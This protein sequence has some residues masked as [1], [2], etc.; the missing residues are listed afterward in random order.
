MT[1]LLIIGAIALAVFWIWLM[2]G[3]ENDPYE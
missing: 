3:F 2:G 1:G